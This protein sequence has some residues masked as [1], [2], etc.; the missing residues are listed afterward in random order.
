MG[1]TADG[2]GKATWGRG[3]KHVTACPKLRL[4]GKCAHVTLHVVQ[5]GG[6]PK[7]DSPP[8]LNVYKYLNIKA[9]QH[10][11]TPFLLSTFS[12]HMAT[13]QVGLFPDLSTSSHPCLRQHYLWAGG[14]FIL[15]ISAL[16]YFLAI[17][18]LKAISPWWYKGMWFCLGMA[19]SEL[20]L[21]T[22]IVPPVSFTGA[23]ISYVI[24]CQSVFPP[25][26]LF[27]CSPVFRKSLG[28]SV[29][30]ICV[31]YPECPQT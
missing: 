21:I 4:T 19:C 30:G 29:T 20:Q 6:R 26:S 24:V 9:C 15:L 25:V 14:H 7:A 18:T 8:G 23:L 17:V 2:K 31:S 12:A 11:F 1:Y 28:V 27:T 3:E 16:R 13:A 5:L 22:L 10:D